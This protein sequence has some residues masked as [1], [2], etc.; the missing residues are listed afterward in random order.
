MVKQQHHHSVSDS[1]MGVN[2]C[3]RSKENCVTCSNQ[4]QIK[5]TT[6]SEIYL[7]ILNKT[8]CLRSMIENAHMFYYSM[9]SNK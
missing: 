4:E 8:N 7:F 9:T 5:T 1:P 3:K 6:R 2:A